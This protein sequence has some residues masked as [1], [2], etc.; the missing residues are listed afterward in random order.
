V[1]QT[2]TPLYKADA[3]AP[4]SPFSRSSSMTA[5]RTFSS[6]SQASQRSALYGC[7]ASGNLTS[8]LSSPNLKV[9]PPHAAC[10]PYRPRAENRLHLSCISSPCFD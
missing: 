3:V 9:R 2:Y 7:K 10:L 5:M 4:E 6:M 8:S 1:V